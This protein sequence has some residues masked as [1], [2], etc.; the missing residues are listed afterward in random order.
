M[1]KTITKTTL[2]ALA[3]GLSAPAMAQSNTGNFDV[4]LTVTAPQQP[5]ISISGLETKTFGNVTQ[6]DLLDNPSPES[7]AT[8][9]CVEVSNPGNLSISPKI[10]FEQVGVTY[11]ENIT[12]RFA[13]VGP[14]MSGT[15]SGNSQIPFT[16]N[17]APGLNG[18][19]TNDYYRDTGWREVSYGSSC[20]S[21]P[22]N[23]PDGAEKPYLWVKRW[24]M[25]DGNTMPG[26][27]QAI[28]LVTVATN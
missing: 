28:I 7:P 18:S 9:F 17:Y 1:T 22:T 21:S 27:Y 6:A 16:P 10:K 2:A 13:L 8:R 19:Y 25:P 3:L 11:N 20:G 15:S 4:T 14:A 23:Y 24:A 26:A 12:N 5:T